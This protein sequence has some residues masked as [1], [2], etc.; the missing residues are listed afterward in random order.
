MK[1]QPKPR[2]IIIAVIAAILMIYSAYARQIFINH[3]HINYVGYMEDTSAVY[4]SSVGTSSL[5]LNN[6]NMHVMRDFLYRFKDVNNEK[7]YGIEGDF[8]AEFS[9]GNV[10]TMVTYKKN[11]EWLYT[12]NSY[13]EK[14]VPEEI[15]ALVKRAYKSYDIVHVKEIDVPNQDNP[16]FLIYLQ[17]ATSIKILR[18]CE[19]EM[20]VLHDYIRG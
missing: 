11:G 10:A 13:D 5:K 19:G 18:V 15:R 17:N 7:W 12:I 4:E 8:V 16:I 9:I 2:T 14:M 20:E 6:I 3:I 1:K